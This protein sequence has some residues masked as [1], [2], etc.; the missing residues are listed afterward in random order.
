[1]SIK[2][3]TIGAIQIFE[4]KKNVTRVEVLQEFVHS[5][6]FQYF[7]LRGG[8]VRDFFPSGPIGAAIEIEAKQFLLRHRK[9]LRLGKID[10]FILKKQINRLRKYGTTLFGY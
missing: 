6:Q 8:T 9:I 7:L 4:F 2:Q 10:Q 1:L 3:V 5:R